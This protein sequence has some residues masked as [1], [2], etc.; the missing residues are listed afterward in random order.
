MNPGQL[1]CVYL[2]EQSNQPDASRKN[3]YLFVSKRL[4]AIRTFDSK[5]HIAG[6][7]AME[8]TS[9]PRKQPRKLRRKKIPRFLGNK[10]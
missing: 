8:D 5:A 7:E 3:I 10:E 6:F 2:K 4:Q 9:G 1:K